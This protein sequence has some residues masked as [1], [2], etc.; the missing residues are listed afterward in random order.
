MLA[1]GYLGRVAASIGA[2]P[3][4]FP[5]T[6]VL[7]GE[8][9]VFGARKDSLVSRATMDAV[10]AFQ[11]DSYDVAER[12]GWSVLG[13]GRASPLDASDREANRSLMSALWG[14]SEVVEQLISI[15]LQ[16]LSGDEVR[17]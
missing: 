15:E 13:V 4:I 7:Q 10:V 9:A 12:S 8:M 6:F 17:P 14:I 16:R 11:V 3:V 2:L 5:V 1:L